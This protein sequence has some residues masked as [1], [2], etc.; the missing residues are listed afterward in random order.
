[1]SNWMRL[2]ACI[3]SV[4]IGIGGCSSKPLPAPGSP[5]PAD[6][7]ASWPR[8]HGPGGDNIS[9]DKGLLGAWPADGPRLVWAVDGIGHGFSGV[10]IADGLIF[11]D[12]NIEGA[13][14]IAALDLSGRIQWQAQNGPA[15]TDSHPGTRGTPTIDGGR[16]Y[17]E[18][19][20]G[21]VVCL[22]AAS[23]DELWSLNILK[24]FG[25][26]NIKWALAESLLIDGENVICCPFGRKASVAALDK[27]S[28]NIVWTAPAVNG[29]AG[30]ASPIVL[31]YQGLR[32][33]L[34]MNAKA[35]V[36]VNA[37]SGELLFR[38]EHITK[39]DVNATMPI[40]HEGQVFVSSGYGAGS[41][42]LRLEVEGDKVAVESVWK[43]SEL[44]NHHGGVILFGGHLYGSSSR[45]RWFCLDWKIGQVKYEEKGVGKGSVTMADGMLYMLNEKRKLGL[46][47]ATP[48]GLELT[49]SFDI[50]SGGE[51]PTW[52]H[53]VVRGGCLYVRHG[54]RLYAYDVRGEP[55]Q[56]P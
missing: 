9:P 49:G 43:S 37:D 17:H 11:T 24:T 56:S 19:P 31:E 4:L 10:T 18:S 25:G 22:D 54:D 44:D 29:A 7:D 13:T 47:P 52:A 32:M 6:A 48:A 8:F 34:T 46:A 50:P 38:H 33:I 16:L 21:N 12:G 5:S 53:P 40:F 3:A 28:G 1:M 45:G 39:Y 20:M 26:T 30:Y 55:T 51:G 27:H 41:E 42:L 2:T 36:G 23:G 14:T 35:L 15:W